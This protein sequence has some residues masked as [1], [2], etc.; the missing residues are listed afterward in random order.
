VV[1][2]GQQFPFVARAAEHGAGSL[3]P[4]LPLTLVGKRSVSESGL[5]DTGAAVNVLPYTLVRCRSWV[6]LGP[7]KHRGETQRKLGNCRSARSPR[8]GGC[9]GFRSGAAGIC[10]GKSGHR[11]RHP[12]PD[13][14]LSGVRCML[15]PSTSALRDS[16]CT[17]IVAD[18]SP[19]NPRLVLTVRRASQARH[20]APQHTRKA[21]GG[22]SHSAGREDRASPEPPAGSAESCLWFR[23]RRRPRFAGWRRRPRFLGRHGEVHHVHERV[24]R[25]VQILEPCT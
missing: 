10:L 3:A 13:Q 21:L 7:A 16:T 24:N 4:M 11:A 25:H 15:L 23:R 2:T 20:G 18:A 17:A 5:L 22:R 12:W 14:L 19:P 6:R 9:S 1:A 8:V